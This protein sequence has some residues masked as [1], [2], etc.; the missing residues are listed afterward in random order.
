MRRGLL[1]IAMAATALALLPAGASAA[2]ITVNTGDDEDNTDLA[3]CSIREAVTSAVTN[4][5]YGGCDSGDEVIPPY[6]SG[7]TADEI[8][9]PDRPYGVTLG[10]IDVGAAGG[11]VLIRS[12]NLSVRREIIRPDNGLSG[13]DRVFNVATG[14]NLTLQALIVRNLDGIDV[15]AGGG[16]IYAR[17]ASTLTVDDS[18]LD[19]DTATSAVTAF[20]GGI[21]R[22]DSGA[23]FTLEDSVVTGGEA[24]QQGGGIYSE[25]ALMTIRRSLIHSNS[26]TRLGGGV[27]A[28]G[29]GSLTIEDSVISDNHAVG[30]PAATIRGGG[31]FSDAGI[32]T[33]LVNRSLISGNT[34]T[35]NGCPPGS[36]ERGGGIFLSEDNGATI[37]NTTIHNNSAGDSSDPPTLSGGGGV[38]RDA[39][40]GLSLIHVTFLDNDAF[41]SDG[42]DH[43]HADASTTYFASLF[44]SAANA[45]VG[46]TTSAGYNAFNIAADPDCDTDITDVTTGSTGVASGVS[47]NGG[48]LVG[49]IGGSPIATAAI[50]SSGTALDLVTV[51]CTEMVDQRG[52]GFTRPQGPACDAGAFELTP[53]TTPP[54]GGATPT[55]PPASP[56][57]TGQRAK[58]LKKCAKKKTKRAKKKCKRRA[59]KLPV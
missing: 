9:L 5:D 49:G 36:A 13:E 58:A 8:Q 41:D 42:A 32:S 39:A 45:C 22:A 20:N 4:A 16:V 25:G 47:N 35:C 33:T 26:A 59:R 37:T 57:P 31:L 24:A 29:L 55:P 48:T 19:G 50:S 43:I 56:G 15:T 51:G 54:P 2:I 3:Q 21:V 46:P 40:S 14:A 7:T 11:P 28:G 10:Q 23:V 27:S 52:T 30:D 12:D 18:L 38:Y 1:G 34:V 44:D 6:G 53:P 17:A